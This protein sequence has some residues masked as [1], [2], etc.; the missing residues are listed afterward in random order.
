MIGKAISG[1]L[2]QTAS[3]APTDRRDRLRFVDKPIGVQQDREGL[4]QWICLPD[5]RVVRVRSILVFW[6]EQIGILG[7]KGERDVWQVE[8]DGAGALELHCTR[9]PFQAEQKILDGEWRLY[10]WLD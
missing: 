1:E 4:P 9:N 6:R 10:R 2:I 5:R 7:R 8:T 3:L